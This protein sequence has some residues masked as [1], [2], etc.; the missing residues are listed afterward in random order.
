MR[1]ARALFRGPLRRTAQALCDG[2]VSVAHAQVLAHG[3]HDLP[4]Q[5]AAEAEPVLLEAARHLDPLRLRRQAGIVEPLSEGQEKTGP[6]LGLLDSA[7]YPTS[8][9]SFD[10]ADCIALFTNG[11]YKVCSPQ[12]DEF[13]RS[14]LDS[15]FLRY[16]DL[17]S[18][19]LCAAVLKDVSGFA[20]R[21]DFDDDVCIVTVEGA[22]Q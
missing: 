7:T 21:S 8:R 9:S 6:A 18:E 11:L 14:A 22:G 16:K 3:T 19:K 17:N 10:D 12:G 13:G 2:E 20:G 4:E 15:T 1:T 5:V